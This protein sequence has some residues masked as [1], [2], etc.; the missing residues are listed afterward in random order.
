[1]STWLIAGVF[2][3][4]A[5]VAIELVIPRIGE[6]RIE[7]SLA[8]DGGE[9]FVGLRA[10]PALQLLW[11]S[12]DRI[13]VRGHRLTLGMSSEGGGLGVLDGFSEVDIVLRDFATGPF[14]VDRLVLE[15]T[16]A[17]P[18][19]LRT[20]ASTTGAALV[21]FGGERLGVPGLL[22]VIARQ[23]PLSGRPV[24]V[25]VEVELRSVDGQVEIAGGG[26]TIA[27]YPAGPLASMLAG[28]VARRLEVSP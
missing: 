7:R 20:A 4:T 12:G 3:A 18:Y 15:R 22:A 10:L 24:P 8:R 27:G 13:A 23:A 21:E 9:A 6:A 19:T 14:A 28:A 2:A 17:E 26:G 5:L 1:M 25:E 11:Q 16:G